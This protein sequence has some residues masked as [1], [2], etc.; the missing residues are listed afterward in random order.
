MSESGINAGLLDREITLITGV[1]TQDSGTGE[2]VI[3]WDAS[4]AGAQVV[5]SQWLPAG[6]KEQWQAQQRLSAYVDGVL[7]LYDISPRPTPD[8]TRIRFQD[9]DF[10]VK[11]VVEI[12]R[13]EG[14]ELAVVARGEG[15]G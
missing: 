14:Y 9:R 13:G 4:D 11:G 8:G 2:E 1:K 15:T 3:V 5:W 6:T 10:D 12:G 7:R